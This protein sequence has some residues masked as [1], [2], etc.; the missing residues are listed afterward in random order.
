MYG[1]NRFPNPDPGQLMPSS[2][3]PHF[4]VIVIGA[5]HAGCEAA[6]ASARVGAR[7]LLLTMNLDH[8]AQMSCNPAIGGVAKGQLVREIDA[9][10]GE[11]GLN[12]DAT[13]IQFN[14][15]NRSKGPAVWSPRAQCDKLLYQRR[16]KH[17]LEAQPNL[18][19][20][21]AEALRLQTQ[22]GRVTG[23]LTQFDELF[24]AKAV[25]VCSGTFLRGLLHYGTKQFA[26]GRAGDA[27][28]NELS[29]SLGGELGLELGRL[30]TGTP[31]RILAAS[32]DFGQ[33]TPQGCEPDGR[34]SHWGEVETPFASL[35][36]V[37][38]PQRGCYMVRTTRATRDLVQANLHLAPMYNGSIKGTGTRYC[39]SFEDKV[40]RF[41]H[42][43]TH[44]IFV[45]PEGAFT[46]EYYLN[47]ISTSLPVTVQRQMIRTL[48]GFARAEISR[49]AY[50]VEYD[51]V[52]PYQLQMSLATRRWPNL[53]LAGQV[54]GTTGYEEAAGQ[55]LLA[56]LNAA[57]LAAGQPP[58]VPGRD[59]AYLGVLVHDLTSKEIREPYRLFTSRAEFRLLLRQDN[60]W[61]RLSKAGY[62][63]GLLSWRRYEWVQRLEA[64]IAAGQQ[65]LRGTRRDGKS[66]WDL[67]RQ[68][69]IALADYPETARLAAAA[70]EQLEVEAHYEGYVE[71]EAQQVAQLQRLEH[72]RIPADFAY[73]FP[74]LR[75]EAR[76]K[77]ERFRPETLGQAARI[78]GVT[79]AEVALIQ[80]HLKRR[81]G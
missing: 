26:A 56:G 38:M 66:L 62:E 41:A 3:S 11:M 25:V 16:M 33:L 28:A 6:L 31:P 79:P 1:S 68:Q 18:V 80:V 75:H 46:E 36:P 8:A 9:L 77:L 40:M 51:F 23:V 20:Q 5:G 2:A 22:G 45:E 50:A 71:R 65:F 57:R 44:Q 63:L 55:G 7:T 81:G 29:A 74:G 17:V 43:E 49:Y 34:F 10:G 64:D 48:P 61:R 52:P 76:S 67:L 14:M 42:H 47:G 73:D 27:P 30:K 35:A 39:P 24:T 37:P 4:E 13:R 72:H 58:F 59:Q 32:I 78:D 54:N 60:A 12:T 15:L 53:F 69:Q 19:V 21:Q 70:R